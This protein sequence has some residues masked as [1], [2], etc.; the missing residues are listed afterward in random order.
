MKRILFKILALALFASHVSAET[1]SL[2]V[3]IVNR[4]SSTYQYGYV[5][6]GYA[7][8]N[9]NVY[10]YGNSASSN[11]SVSG[12][13]A[14]SASFQVQGETLSLLLPDSRIVV[15]NC[16]PKPNWTDWNQGIHRS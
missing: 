7:S 14:L 6:P 12:M 9:C 11:C 13:P 16:A 3:Q 8:S 15:V 5:V 4:K 10:S 2:S 1:L